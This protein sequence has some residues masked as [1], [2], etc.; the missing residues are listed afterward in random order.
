MNTLLLIKRF[1]EALNSRQIEYC[2]WK[3][4]HAIKSF[5]QG[6]G[7]LDI[8]VSEN[9]QNEFKEALSEF[10]FKLAVSP[11]WEETAS[12]FHYY[13]LDEETGKVVHL[14]IYFKLISGGMLIKNYHLLKNLHLNYEQNRTAK[15]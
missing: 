2:H 7:D 13:G 8:L 3:S 4:N 10:N 12:V 6:E 15:S 9:S 11:A 5:L 14:H 1:F